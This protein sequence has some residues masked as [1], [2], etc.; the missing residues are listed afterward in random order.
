L[1]FNK[2]NKKAGL[3]IWIDLYPDP[4]PVL[5]PDKALDFNPDPCPDLREKTS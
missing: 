2:Q 4:V 3:W 5:N 1:R